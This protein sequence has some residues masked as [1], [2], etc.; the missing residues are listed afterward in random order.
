MIHSLLKS[1]QIVVAKNKKRAISGPSLYFSVS[2]KF[3]LTGDMPAIA[4]KAVVLTH[5]IAFELGPA[6]YV[7]SPF[8]LQFFLVEA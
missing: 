4:V 1:C 5:L 2:F 3:L 7:I 8:L 6:D